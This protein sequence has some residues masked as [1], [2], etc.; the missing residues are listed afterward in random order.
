MRNDAATPQPEPFDDPRH[1]HSIRI[2][3]PDLSATLGVPNAC[4]QCHTKQTA[5][6]AADAVAKLQAF[7]LQFMPTPLLLGFVRK[8][9]AR[10]LSRQGPPLIQPYR[11]LIR[12]LRKEVVLADNASC[13]H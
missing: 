7:F 4:N 9:K 10:L 11:D 6:W 13:G 8:V 2:P 3:R 1:D 12:L 5:K